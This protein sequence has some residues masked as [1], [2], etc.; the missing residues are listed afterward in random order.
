VKELKIYVD[1]KYETIILP[2][3]GVPVPLHIATIKNI[4]TSKEADYMYLR[5]N[6][7]HPGATQMLGE[8]DTVPFYLFLT[9]L[10]TK[11]LRN[12]FLR[13]RD[14]RDK[15]NLLSVY[16]VFNPGRIRWTS[17]GNGN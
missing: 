3:F 12:Y 2:I 5:I 8:D 6:F 11:C 17:M 13:I 10:K 9:R 1:K 7:F 15:Q 14:T 16:S 4:S